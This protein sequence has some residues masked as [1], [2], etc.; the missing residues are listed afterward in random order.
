MKSALLLFAST[1]VAAAQVSNQITS[2]P[3]PPYRI[4]VYAVRNPAQIN[5][6]RSTN[7]W[8]R[9]VT[10]LEAVSPARVVPLSSSP[11]QGCGVAVTPRHVYGAT[12]SFSLTAGVR[13][14]FVTADN[15]VVERQSIGHTNAG[16]DVS[17]ALLDADLPPEIKPLRIF[18][19][20]VSAL[21]CVGLNQHDYAGVFDATTGGTWFS[22]VPS[23]A[24][25]DARIF[26]A[27]G[28]S[29]KPLMALVGGELALVG[30]WTTP[31]SG[32][33]LWNGRTNYNAALAG[34]SAGAGAPVYEL[35]GFVSAP[36]GLRK[37]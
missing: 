8:L 25:P 17:F 13:M 32:A 11:N 14:W 24:Y 15:R 16:E 31:S 33:W 7:C 4:E 6:V 19:G 26:I 35:R 3:L 18:S 1:C 23:Q 29:G 21:Q 10:G 28:D 9:G 2:H 22:A 37:L 27:F 36:K 5:Y 34:L 12:H 30:G 20:K